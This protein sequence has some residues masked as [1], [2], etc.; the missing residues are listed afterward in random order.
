MARTLSSSTRDRVP[1]ADEPDTT[2]APY[3]LF[4][5]ASLPYPAP[6]TRS[7]PFR[8]ALA[9]LV[10]RTAA[11]WSRTPAVT[12]ALHSAM[13]TQA[14]PTQAMPTQA[15]PDRRTGFQQRVLLPV[16]RDIHNNRMPRPALIEALSDT[17]D[18]IPGLADWLA[19]RAEIGALADRVERLLPDALAAERAALAAMCAENPLRKAAALSGRDLLH[20]IDRTAGRRGEPDKRGRKAEQAILRYALRTS[21]KTS[22]L[23]WYTHVGF[24]WWGPGERLWDVGEPVAVARVNRALLD[25]IGHAVLTDPA[26]RDRFGHHL[27]PGLRIRGERVL[28]RRDVPVAGRTFATREEQVEL[29]ASGPLRFLVGLVRA[30]SPRCPAPAELAEALAERLGGAQASAAAAGYVHK[31]I[32]SGVLVAAAPVH[33]QHPDRAGPLAAWLAEQGLAD[34][35]AAVL[36]LDERTTAFSSL[37]AGERPAALA[38]LADGWARAA[39]A[40]PSLRIDLTG[41]PP[42]SEDVVLPGRFPLGGRHGQ[43]SLPTLARLTPFL[44]LFDQQALVRLMVRDAFVERFGRGAAIE[45]IALADLLDEVVPTAFTVGNRPSS[46][47][48]D[49]LSTA[50]CDLLDLR[51]ALAALIEAD[52]VPG[53]A[54]RAIPEHVL[55]MAAELL[56]EWAKRRTASYSLFVQPTGAGLV[57]N[58]AYAGFGRFTSRFLDYLDPAARDA[59]AAQLRLLAGDTAQLRPVGGFN[60]NLHPAVT[61]FEIGDD[62]TWADLTPDQVEAYHDERTDQIRLREVSSGR[63]INVLYLGFLIPSMLPSRMAALHFD[64]DCGLPTLGPLTP[65]D[66]VAGVTRKGRLTC[67]DVVLSRRSWRFA[68]HAVTELLDV[69]DTARSPALAAAELRARHGMPQHVFVG[70]AGIVRSWEDFGRQLA[71]PKSQYVDLGNA[72]HLRHL[73]KV[74]GRFSAGVRFTEALPVPGDNPDGR[75]V[76]LIVETYRRGQ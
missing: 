62:P 56:P 34:L 69:L 27:A 73:A 23:S 76:E 75:V 41:V 31:L 16:R 51:T 22:P 60:A 9:E 63:T 5:V 1:S 25:R 43:D 17:V 6:P 14:M 11:L 53:T 71:D 29:R 64:L 26:R 10:D 39:D 7:E 32:D 46:W 65:G 12:E 30:A 61:G 37:P 15:M 52:S 57:V 40:T 55:R 13:P 19:E 68:E 67:G 44:M 59:V 2:V 72:L 33:P 38:G 66:A 35:A 48:A 50:V 47:R 3:A 70:A 8:A 74:V 54:D 4:R 36:R 42:L 49:G 21:T 24:G 45:L 58:H 18:D 28:F 20:G